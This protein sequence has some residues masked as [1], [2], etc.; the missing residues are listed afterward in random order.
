MYK[1]LCDDCR[2]E[3]EVAFYFHDKR[4]ITHNANALNDH[5]Y[6]EATCIG[7]A[8]CPICG[9]KLRKF[10]SKAI[11]NKSIVDLAVGNNDL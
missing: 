10:F 6:Y 1:V 9:C 4:I 7:D 3:V 5:A 2:N 8:I 11:S